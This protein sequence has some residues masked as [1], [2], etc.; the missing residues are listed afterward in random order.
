MTRPDPTDCF[1]VS[2]GYRDRPTVP[3]GVIELDDW[4]LK[5]YGIRFQDPAPDGARVAAAAL[6]L[7]PTVLPS[8]AQAQGR[9]GVGFVILHEGSGMHYV[10][11]GWWDRENELPVVIWVRE[12]G[13]EEWRPAEGVE[14]FCV[15]DLQVM[16]HE[17]DAYVEHVLS[18]PEAP[19]LD[20]YLGSRVSR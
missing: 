2:A 16:A 18:K 19:D 8:P 1:A 10:V 3:A 6:P 13:E 14:S 12:E 4:R 11:L 5:A 7:A 17:R 20:A 9:P 15:W